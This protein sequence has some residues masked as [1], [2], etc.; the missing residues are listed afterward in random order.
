MAQTF[1]SFLRALAAPA[2]AA[3]LLAGPAAAERISINDAPMLALLGSV[4]GPG[5]YNEVYRGATIRPPRPVSKMTIA[6]VLAFQDRMVEA[7][8][9]SSAIG[10]YQ[11]IRGTLREL[12]RQ[13]RID[14]RATFDARTQDYLARIMLANCGFYNPEGDALEVGNCLAQVWA[15][16]P[17]LSGKNA[18]RS[19]YHGRAGNR[20]LTTITRVNKTLEARFTPRAPLRRAPALPAVRLASVEAFPDDG[21]F[22]DKIPLR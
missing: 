9:I 15:A 22:S 1:R 21:R 3:S 19:Y 14:V 18:G 20:A 12:V 13:N 10:R 4:E 17:V 8:S 16:L 5:G 2:L 6:E 7:G 11:F